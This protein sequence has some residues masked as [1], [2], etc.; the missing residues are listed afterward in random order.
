VLPGFA[1]LR[2]QTRPR[3]TA[4]PSVRRDGPDRGEVE[5]VRG[6][7]ID[8]IAQSL[9]LSRPTVRDHVKAIFFE[10]KQSS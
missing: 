3:G 8:E 2:L 9:W 10:S 1:G 6:L 4:E 7:T 5:L